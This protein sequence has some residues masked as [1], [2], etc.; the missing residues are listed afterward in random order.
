MGKTQVKITKIRVSFDPCYKICSVGKDFL[1]SNNLL[2]PTF[3]LQPL[4]RCHTADVQRVVGLLRT[5]EVVD[6][7]SPCQP[8]W[9][10]IGL[11]RP[12]FCFAL[13]DVAFHAS[14]QRGDDLGV[15][16]GHVVV[17]LRVE[18]QI[19]EFD[20][21]LE[22]KIRFKCEDQLPFGGAPAMFAHPGAF[23]DVEV[24]S[25]ARRLRRAIIGSR[26]RPSKVWLHGVDPSQI[27]QRGHEVFVLVVALDAFAGRHFA[28]VADDQRHMQH[29]VIH[30]VMVEAAL[31]FVER[32]AVVAVEAMIVSSRMP[33]FSSALK[34][35]WMQASM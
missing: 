21:R 1:L 32:L 16:L 19:V 34:I 25:R 10:R 3:R 15:L 2:L 12:V 11:G 13:G 27:E 8:G 6:A 35:V 31:V 18:H 23:G 22:V 20:R 17:F 4:R 33:C 29:V 7:L 5:G 26:L 14:G 30:A 9:L 28:R 24:A